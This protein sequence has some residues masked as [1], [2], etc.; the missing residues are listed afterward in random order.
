VLRSSVGVLSTALWSY[1]KLAWWG[2]VTPRLK[3]ADERIV[4]QAV[5]VSD[6]G[7]L[8]AVRSDLRGWELPGGHLEAGERPEDALMREVREETG[9]RI[10]IERHVGDYVRTGFLPHRAVVYLCRY[11]DG[12]LRSSLENRALR[13]FTPD[14][15]PDTLFPWYR[16]PLA[17][18]FDEAREPVTH[19]EHL[20]ASDIW[21]GMRIDLRMRFSDDSTG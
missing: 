21:A 6:A 8:L 17:D 10:A 20:G 13:W 1:T 3:R 11:V 9:V 4:L 2:L 15:I 5:V 12:S 18:A 14:E 19:R 7:V 16:Q